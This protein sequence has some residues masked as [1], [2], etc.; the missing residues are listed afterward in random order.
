MNQKKMPSHGVFRLLGI[1]NYLG[2][3]ALDAGVCEENGEFPEG[4]DRNPLG[5]G[6]TDREIEGNF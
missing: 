2:I 3:G 5:F 4:Y 6:E 1:T